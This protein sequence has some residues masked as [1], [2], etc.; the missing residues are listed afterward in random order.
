MEGGPVTQTAPGELR[1]APILPP[2]ASPTAPN[3]KQEPKQEG[4]VRPET[5]G[6][7]PTTETPK[8]E[9]PKTENGGNE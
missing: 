8:A 7:T 9:N 2:M 3:W 6:E 1:S 5:G 4:L